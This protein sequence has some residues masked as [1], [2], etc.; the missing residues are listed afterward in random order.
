MK[1][2]ITGGAGFLGAWI[3]KRLL[4]GGHDVCIFDRNDDRRLLRLIVG[5]EAEAVEWRIGDVTRAEEVVAASDGC[6][7]IAHLAGLLTPACR[8]DPIRGANVNLIGTINVFE[9]ARQHGIQSIAYASSAGVFGPSD[10]VVPFPMT[11]YGTFK[12]A[13]EGVARAYAADYEIASVGFRPLT[14]YGPG[15]E[16]GSSAGPSIACRKVAEGEAYVIPF[17]GDTDIIFVDDV[18]A[19]FEAALLRPVSGA[20]VFNLRGD[21]VSIDA[22]VAEIRRVV[23]NAKLS[24][25]G[26]QPPIAADLEAHDVEATLGTLQRTSLA[27][28]LKRTI[29]FYENQVAAVA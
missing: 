3:A 20:H 5:P 2:L 23:P 11:L 6:D 16:L 18:A 26:D 29:A 10:G 19:A 17:T 25:E 4:A 8:A 28:G 22:I 27:D 1:I 14:V 9:A 15:R 24:A 21:L 7:R 12:L 13:C